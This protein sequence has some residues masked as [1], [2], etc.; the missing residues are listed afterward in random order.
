MRFAVLLAVTCFTSAAAASEIAITVDDLPTTG[1][2]PVGYDRISIAKSIIMNLQKHGVPGVYGFLNAKQLDDY[3]EHENIIT[4]WTTA[5]FPLGNHTYSHLNLESVPPEAFIADIRKN[6]TH[7]KRLSVSS[8]YKMFR[9]PFLREGKQLERHQAVRKALLAD[10]Y[11]IAPVTIYF[12]DW[13]WNEAYARCVSKKNETEIANLKQTYLKAAAEQFA[14]VNSV[15][16]GDD[17]KQTRQVLLLHLNAFNSIMLDAL[18]KQYETS[19]AKYITL[20]RAL[21]D[22]V[23]QQDPPVPSDGELTY[24]QRAARANAKPAPEMP[25][26]KLDQVCK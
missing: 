2:L 23:L 7:L 21:K 14:W 16:V 12:D 24:W 19:G 11:Q 18:L 9:Y 25:L 15:S 13:A 3:P 26:A 6:E 1:S 5:G 20:E 22:P 10:G 17:G 8:N 4:E